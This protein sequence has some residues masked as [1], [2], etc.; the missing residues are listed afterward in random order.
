MIRLCEITIATIRNSEYADHSE[1]IDP[2]THT[3]GSPS[4]MSHP[5]SR[6]SSTP[7]LIAYRG[8]IEAS[9]EHRPYESG[10]RIF[11]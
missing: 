11:T 4:R 9:H 5:G 7:H 3:F 10:L 1:P 8:V 6:D 2:G